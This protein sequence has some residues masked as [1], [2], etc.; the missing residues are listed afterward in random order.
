MNDVEM[1]DVEM[2][3]QDDDEVIEG[4]DVED[5]G[6]QNEEEYVPS[7][8]SV[9]RNVKKQKKRVKSEDDQDLNDVTFKK[10]MIEEFRTQNSPAI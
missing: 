8:S 2:M 4:V 9:K 6:E 3:D 1:N 5:E 7:S 10:T